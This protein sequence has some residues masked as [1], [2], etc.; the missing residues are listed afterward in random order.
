MEKNKYDFDDLNKIQKESRLI[1][2]NLMIANEL[3]N[4]YKIL[5]EKMKK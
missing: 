4:I 3:N 1:Y 2:V 5:R